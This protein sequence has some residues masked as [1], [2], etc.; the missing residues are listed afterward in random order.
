MQYILAVSGGVDSVVLLDMVARRRPGPLLVA[1]FDHGIRP[2][3]AEDAKFVGQLA[4]QYQ[5]P[6]ISQREALGRSASEATARHHRYAFLHQ[7]AAQYGGTLMTAHHLD[8]VVETIALNLQR[9]TRWRGLAG[10]SDPRISRPLIG[11]TKQQLY[12]YA[13]AHRLEWIE[14]ET[15][16]SARYTRNRLRSLL[17]QVPD[18]QRR[19]LYHLW[20]AQRQVRRQIQQL[21]G[22]WDDA[23]LASR[24]F[25]IMLPPEV[26]REI[27]YETVHR[28]TGVS[29][30]AA[31][32]ERLLLAIK[33][34]RPGTTWQITHGVE[35]KLTARTVII[36]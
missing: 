6:Y 17:Q 19:Q 5:L 9:G 21:L 22:E 28:R 12:A 24:Y 35:V 25:Y 23:Q 16:H 30:L 20:H 27:I 32:V 8:D 34:G 13:L 2:T 18:Q 29:L 33:T 36:E 3:S 15:N 14:D 4:A 7:L 31:Q 1:H 11:R 26:A 10:L